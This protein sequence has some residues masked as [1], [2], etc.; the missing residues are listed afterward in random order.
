[1]R[2]IDLNLIPTGKGTYIKK[3]LTWAQKHTNTV[4]I[5]PTDQAKKDYIS[6]HTYWSKVK[7]TFIDFFGNKCWYSDMDLSIDFGDIDHFRPKAKSLDEQKKI[8][9]VASV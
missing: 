2:Y 5:L 1:M 7:K 8:I 6:N 3:W 9:L 4:S